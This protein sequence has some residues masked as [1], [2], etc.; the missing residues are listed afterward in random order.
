MSAEQLNAEAARRW[1]A[2]WA[3]MEAS[4]GR[5]RSSLR[6]NLRRRAVYE[7][8]MEPLR[9]AGCECRTC[10]HWAEHWDGGRVC[11]LHSDHDG[12]ARPNP[13]YLCPDWS[14]P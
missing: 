5:K 3:R 14:R 4:T 8:A 11:S 2:D 9:A 12:Y 10:K 1:P 6:G 13:D 7:N